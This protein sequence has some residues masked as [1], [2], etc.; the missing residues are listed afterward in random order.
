VTSHEVYKELD[1]KNWIAT[2]SVDQEEFDTLVKPGD[3]AHVY[4]M[5]VR[6]L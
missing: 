6:V 2:L 4:W 3:P 5:M 1:T